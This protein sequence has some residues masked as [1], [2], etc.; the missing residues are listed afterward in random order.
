MGLGLPLVTH[1]FPSKEQEV[2]M[3]SSVNQLYNQHDFVPFELFEQWATNGN[4]ASLILNWL[5][6]DLNVRQAFFAESGLGPDTHI[7]VRS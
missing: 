2:R 6:I 4:S 7:S 3:A 1:P 5:K